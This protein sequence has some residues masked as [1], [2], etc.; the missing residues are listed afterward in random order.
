MNAQCLGHANRSKAHFGWKIIHL[1][2]TTQ[3]SGFPQN[4][5]PACQT[6]TQRAGRDIGK[7]ECKFDSS[8]SRFCSH[9]TSLSRP[10]YPASL[11]LDSPHNH[12][13]FPFPISKLAQSCG[14]FLIRVLVNH[15]RQPQS[16]DVILGERVQR[17]CFL[18][19]VK[20]GSN[21]LPSKGDF[22]LDLDGIVI[23]VDVDKFQKMNGYRHVCRVIRPYLRNILVVPVLQN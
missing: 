10:E 15:F 20:G 13:R 8:P 22:K 12:I 16:L 6:D 9:W 3:F 4:P 7:C 19:I 17:L 23:F 14:L 2:F 1:I 21:F 11:S 18:Q 5:S